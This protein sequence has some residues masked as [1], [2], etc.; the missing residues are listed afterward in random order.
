[1]V[2]K[3]I[4]KAKGSTLTTEV[5]CIAVMTARG[6]T[7]EKEIKEVKM[8]PVCAFSDTMKSW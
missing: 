1:M 3:M 2:L 7:E 5:L 8:T 6:G 4:P